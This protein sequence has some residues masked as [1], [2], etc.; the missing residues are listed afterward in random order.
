[1][2][3]DTQVFTKDIIENIVQILRKG[4]SCEVKREGNQIVIVEINRKVKIK[5]PTIG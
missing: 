2:N 4:G 3:I 5:T 1:M